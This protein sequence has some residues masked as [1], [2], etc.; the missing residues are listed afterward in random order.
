MNDSYTVEYDRPR[1]VWETIGE[2]NITVGYGRYAF[3][4]DAL[5]LATQLLTHENALTVRITKHMWSAE[6]VW[7]QTTVKSTT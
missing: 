5:R 1:R 7:E 2:G 3:Y 4:E 6:T